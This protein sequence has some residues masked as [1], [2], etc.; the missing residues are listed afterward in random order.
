MQSIM[1]GLARSMTVLFSQT[2][3]CNENNVFN[4]IKRFLR[5]NR[6]YRFYISSQP[7]LLH[8]KINL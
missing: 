7:T 6:H 8:V 4:K 2:K 5:Q 3:L 1:P